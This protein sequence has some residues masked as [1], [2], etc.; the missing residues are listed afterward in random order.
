MKI[1]EKIINKIMDKVNINLNQNL[2]A[3][4]VSLVGI[5]FSEHYALPTLFCFSK[6]LGLMSFTSFGVTLVFYTVRYCK[7]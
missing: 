3:V 2:W 1:I 4:V 6:I 7:K 5:G